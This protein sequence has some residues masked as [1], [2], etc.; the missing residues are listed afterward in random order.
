MEVLISVQNKNCP[1]CADPEEIESGISSSCQV[2]EMSKS[3]TD[4]IWSCFH[5]IAM[6]ALCSTNFDQ[7]RASDGM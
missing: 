5:I 3:E 6:G 2:G 4:F 1:G 7:I